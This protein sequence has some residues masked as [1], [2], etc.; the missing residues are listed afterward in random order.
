VFA[1][2]EEGTGLMSVPAGGGD[3]KVLT[4]P[5]TAR[6][7][8]DHWFPSV[9]PGGRAVLFTIVSGDISDAQVAVL[10]LAT[11]EQK[12]LIRGGSSAE[13]VE[14]GDLVYAIAGSLRA[15]RFDPVRLEM[16]SDPVPVVEDVEIASTGAANFSV[17]RT[18][19]LVY[20]PSGALGGQAAPRSLAWVT[21]RGREEPVKV[22]ARAYFALRLSPD[23]T[24]VALDIRDQENDIWVWDFARQ[25]L[26]RLTFDR[27]QDIFP[28][29]TAISGCSRWTASDN[30]VCLWSRFSR[31]GLRKFRP[32]AD[33]R[34]HRAAARTRCGRATAGNCS[35]ATALVL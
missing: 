24:R 9:L 7:E 23:G 25:T 26:T 11:G 18:G 15:V 13:Y 20:M 16:L 14:T 17:S 6:G 8:T 33:G 10:D 21:R 1:T 31:K 5:D 3:P 30:Q 28:V 22:P 2:T 35:I 4:T 32:T 12:V 34:C 19:A 27:G 29:W